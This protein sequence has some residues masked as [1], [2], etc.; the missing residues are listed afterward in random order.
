MSPVDSISARSFLLS[1]CQLLQKLVVTCS[2][3]FNSRAYNA[4]KSAICRAEFVVTDGS[5]SFR[6][7][8]F[9]SLVCVSLVISRGRNDTVANPGETRERTGP[10]ATFYRERTTGEKKKNERVTKEGEIGRVR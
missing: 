8:F 3:C 1:V 6:L 9:L 7:I 10:R 5:L 2:V 4:H